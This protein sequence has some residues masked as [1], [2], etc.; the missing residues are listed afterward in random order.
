VRQILH[1][2]D[3]GPKSERMTKTERKQ[4]RRV[5]A[6][7]D[8]PSAESLR[9]MPEID[10]ETARWFKGRGPE[11]RRSARAFFATVRGRPRKGETAAGT[12]TR[13]LRLADAVWTELE[14]IAAER[15]TTVHALLRRLVA[16]FLYTDPP[17]VA[18]ERRRITK[19]RAVG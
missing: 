16:E 6:R 7:V 18:R 9:G 19:R 11:G 10:V 3:A 13:S 5:A 4:R 12:T 8:E 2:H 1:F 17:R 15:N 14:R